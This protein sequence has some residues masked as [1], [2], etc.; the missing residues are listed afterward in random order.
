M[1]EADLIRLERRRKSNRASA[2]KYRH[3]KERESDILKQVL[4]TLEFKGVHFKNIRP[5]LYKMIYQ[6]LVICK[7]EDYKKIQTN[8]SI[9]N[10]GYLLT[11]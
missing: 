6:C 9:S 1:T 7:N 8:I 10:I 11:V 5:T 3:K 4:H 2:E